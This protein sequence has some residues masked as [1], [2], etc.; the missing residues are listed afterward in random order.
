MRRVQRARRGAAVP[1][2]GRR[3][4]RRR[5][6][7]SPPELRR[8]LRARRRSR[9]RYAQHAR[10][11]SPAGAAGRRPDERHRLAL[12]PLPPRGHPDD[13]PDQ[14]VVGRRA[15]TA[16]TPARRN[17]AA[18]SASR[19]R[20]ASRNRR[21]NV[22]SC[23]ST[24]SC[25]PVSASSMSI[26]PTSGSST[27]RGSYSRT[28]MTSCR[29]V[30]AS[31]ARSQPGALMK[32]EITNTSER[33]LIQRCPASSSGARSVN[34]ADRLARVRLQVVDEPQHLDPAAARPGS[35]ARRSRP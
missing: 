30:S 18:R 34:G 8:P 1:G 31:S 13:R 22:G 12:R 15:Q 27:S 17:A 21:R 4:R 10:P 3:C 11:G 6:R 32:S 16:S 2:A 33:P 23:V 24:Y 29:R 20:A 35:S 26:G 19:A 28:A 25:S 9:D 14:V 7:R 5:R